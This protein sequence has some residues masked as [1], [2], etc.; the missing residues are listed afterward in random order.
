MKK[1]SEDTLAL[2][3]EAEVLTGENYIEWTDGDKLEGYVKEDYLKILED[4]ID[5]I[6]T[7]EFGRRKD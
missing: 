2:I 6:R 4:L 1:D 3:Q 5:C 7:G